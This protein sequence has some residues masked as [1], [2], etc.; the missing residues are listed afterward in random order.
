MKIAKSYG[1]VAD[2][3]SKVLKLEKEKD[4]Q[5]ISL[6][7]YKDGM[8]VGSM[9]FSKAEA[10][11]LKELIAAEIG[12]KEPEKK[13]EEVPEIVQSLVSL[14][15][16]DCGYASA[17]CNATREDLEKAIEI[18]QK[19]G[20]NATR[21]KACENAI[22]RIDNGRITE[23]KE[24]VEGTKEN[25]A[26]T[27]ENKVEEKPKIVEFPS[28]D[29]KPKIIKLVT[30]GDRTYGECVVKLQKEAEQ[31]KDSDSEYVIAGLIELCKV[32]PDFR[33]N[34]MREDKS[35]GG[36]MEYMFKA[37][38]NGYCVKY[39]NVGWLDRDTALGLAI[40]Y[41]NH[42][43]EKAEA[44]EKKKREEEALRRKIAEEA[45]KKNGKKTN[46]KKK[47]RTA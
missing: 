44:E 12:Y 6:V 19:G 5:G 35:Y 46:R 15:T 9:Q 40:D 41:Y 4:T 21:I 38:Q 14:P 27:K 1:I 47:S 26:E 18:M 13:N 3:G 29:K 34:L 25:K 33:N 43:S 11:A 32:D 20:R 7:S 22:K 31:F 24:K 10:K 42:D 45:K 2:H 23:T 28:E 36:F 16:S 17:L 39:G 30:E 8:G 37:A